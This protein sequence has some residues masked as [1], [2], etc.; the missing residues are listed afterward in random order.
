MSRAGFQG[1]GTFTLDLSQ[2][3]EK[4]GGL[5]RFRRILKAERRWPSKGALRQRCARGA[6]ERGRTP[7][8]LG[9]SVYESRDERNEE[10]RS[11][12]WWLLNDTV[13]S[14]LILKATGK[15]L[16]SLFVC[17]L[18]CLKAGIRLAWL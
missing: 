2:Q 4:R 3:A 17:L 13:S 18:V 14:D 1:L 10:G 8:G 9:Y 12:M 5:E 15:H 6:S 11:G 7:T 16:S